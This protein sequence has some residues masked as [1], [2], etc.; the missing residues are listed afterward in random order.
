MVQSERILPAFP[1]SLAVCPGEAVPLHIF[2][3]RYKSM[4]AH[5]RAR[6]SEGLPGEFVIVCSDGSDWR[7]VGCVMRIA[8]LLR[9]YD[10]GRMDLI[11]I[12]KQRCAIEPADEPVPYPTALI[13]PYEDLSTE[14]DESVANQVFYLHRRL[15]ALATGS[16]P[17]E[18]EYSGLATLS[19]RVMPTSALSLL[20]KQELL[21]MRSEND[22]LLSLAEH[23]RDSVDLLV[24]AER[25]V[26][27]IQNARAALAAVRAAS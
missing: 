7:K 3:P 18:S 22:R 4:I 26:L 20:R 16:E 13:A 1:L 14:W 5:C 24:Q 19:F 10:D 15:I 12:G 17:P 8:T 27:A 6:E 23:L 25:S 21:E 11:A 2:E 9:T